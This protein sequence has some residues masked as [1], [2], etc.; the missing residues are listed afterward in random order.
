MFMV[1]GALNASPKFSLEKC[2]NDADVIIVG[3]LHF[4][5]GSRDKVVSVK[6]RKV[7]KGSVPPRY[8]V[9]FQPNQSR[10]HFTLRKSNSFDYESKITEYIYI[11]RDG[12]SFLF[13]LGDTKGILPAT[14]GNVRLVKS[15]IEKQG[16]K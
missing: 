7:L 4:M 16:D 10:L 9:K 2:V 15:I 5:F 1:A 12:K 13:V 6:V 8:K 3:E 11:L 14:E